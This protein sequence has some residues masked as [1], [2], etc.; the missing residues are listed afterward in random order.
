MNFLLVEKKQ[1]WVSILIILLM[2]LQYVP[3]AKA[4]AL[5]T[6]WSPNPIATPVDLYGVSYGGGQW[7][8]VGEGTTIAQSTDGVNWTKKALAGTVPYAANAFYDALYTGSKW[9]IVGAFGSLIPGKGNM[10]QIYTSP[11]G[12]SWTSKDSKVFGVGSNLMSIA[13]NGNTLVAVGNVNYVTP[14]VTTS[15]DGGETW[16]NY[17]SQ[18]GS[19]RYPLNKV[20]YG[21][22]M[23]VAVGDNGNLFT[24]RNG[25]D[26]TPQPSNTIGHLFG[27]VYTN[28][29]FYVVGNGVL[30]TSTDGVTWTNNWM[31]IEYP[32]IASSG[33]ESVIVDIMGKVLSSIDG[34]TW[35]DNNSGTTT[36]LWN[37]N[38]GNGKFVTV[39]AAGITATRT[40]IPGYVPSSNADLS[41]LSLS[42]GTLTP[43][44][45]AA[46]MNYT[47]AVSNQNSIDVT[48]LT[49]DA[50]AKVT[51][52]GMAPVSGNK[53]T[54]PLIA[55]ANT[56]AIKVTAEDN[57]TTRTY[58]VTIT[59]VVGSPLDPF[60]NA[61]TVDEMRTAMEGA[62]PL[63]IFQSQAG[64]D[65]FFSNV[66]NDKDY[67]YQ[68][69]LDNRGGGFVNQKNL[70]DVIGD[71]IE[72]R[73]PY[74][75]LHET[76]D[77]ASMLYFAYL[78]GPDFDFGIDLSG[79]MSFIIDENML[80][81]DKIGAKLSARI[82]VDGFV[83]P[84]DLQ[85]ALD[86]SIQEYVSE[87]LV[88]DKAN[89]LIGYAAGDSE[90]HV[91][92]NL[93]LPVTGNSGLT[94]RII[95]TSNYSFINANGN[96]T[97]PTSSQGN[98]TVT[99]TATM[100]KSGAVAVK[101]FTVL[102]K[103]L[104]ITGAEAV[105]Q[106]KSLLDI[107]YNGTDSASSVTQNVSLKTSGQNGTTITWSSNAPQFI[108][109][110]GTV[111][112]PSFIQ[113]DQTVI[114]TATITKNGATATKLFTLTL[115][116]M[117][118]S[119][120]EA[121][122]NDKASLD[123]GYN[124]TDSASSV[125][126]NVMLKTAGQFGSTISWS[127]NSPAFIAADGTVTRPTYLQ[128]DQTVTLTATIMKNGVVDTKQFML[129]IVK[130]PMSD[131]EAVE[132][133]KAG[134]NV[135]YNGS[136][137]N[138]SVTQNVILK[139]AGEN[140]TTLTW[141]SNSPAFIAADG[142]VT[143]PTYLQGDQTVILTATITKNGA[144]DTKPFTLT[145]P[146]MP[147]SDSEAVG[148]DKAGLE[149]GYNGTDSAASVMQ[150]VILKTAG[151]AGTTISWSTDSPAFITADGKV[152]RP[153]Y[154][155]GDQT[156][157]LTATIMKNGAVDTKQF[158][159]TVV[160]LPMSDS[161]AVMLDKAGLNVGYNGSD[162]ATSVTQKVTLKTVGGNGTTITWSSNSPAF[163][164]ADG[165]VTRP[166]YLQGD[167]TV[168]LTATIT[169]NGATD[170]KPF[171]LTLP[172]MP[173]SDSEA[174]GIDK[175]GLE[176]G[177]NG[178]DSAS[179]VAQNVILKTAGPAGTTISWSTDSPAFIAADGKVTR[180]TYLQGD[181]TV[182]LT[183]TI[184]KNG[185]VDTKQFTV[186]VVKLPMS[187]WE[188]V[189]IEKAGL[190][191]GYNGADSATSVTQN[192][193][194]KTA[195]ENGTTISW[196]SNTPA[197][198]AAD[199]K[200]TR[201]T[202]LQGDQT[203]TLT[204]T[205]MKNGAVDTKQFTLT[206][207]KLPMNDSE[208]VELDKAGLNV[209]Y[210]VLDSATSVIQNVT[211][212][213]V[214]EN[215]TTITWSSNSAAFVAA[216]GTVTRPS[217]TEGDQ[218]VTLTATITKNGATDIKTFTL[219]L[220]KLPMTDA[221]AVTLD[222]T[223]LEIGYNGADNANSV[224]DNVVLE[225]AGQYGTTITWSSSNPSF[226]AVDGTVTRPTFTQGDQIVTLTT[227]IT[228][229]GATDIKTFTITLP[230]LPMT[231]AE[232]VTLFKTSL[233]IG[234]NGADNA[235]SVTDNIVLETAGQFGT[236]ITWSSSNPSFIAADGTVTRPTFT[237]G[238]QVVTLTATITKNG[239][240]DIKTFTLTLPKLPMTDAEAVMLDKTSLE[241]GYNG[242]DNANSVTDNIVLETAGQFGTTITWS[243]SNPSV[244]AADGTVTRPT[245]TQGDQI[246]T[247]TATIT[248][249][250]ATDIKTFTL[251]LTKLPI[252]DSEAVGIEKDSLGIGY[253]GADTANSV[254]NHLILKTAGQ[255]GTTVTWSS[256]APEFVAA[257]G[258]VNRP[259]YTQ[260]DQQVNLTAA[261]HRGSVTEVK[262]FTL[263]LPHLPMTDAEAV[264]IEKGLLEI[265]YN[266]NNNA[267]SVTTNVMLKT[268]GTNGTTIAW[269]SN[270]PVHVTTDGKVTRPEYSNGHLKVTVTAT[271]TK[272]SSSTTKTFV[273]TL[274]KLPKPPVNEPVS[275]TI[276]VDVVSGDGPN[277]FLVQTEIKRTTDANGVIKDHVTFTK[278][279]AL[280][281]IERM[282][283]L[284]SKTARI[285][286][287]DS[288][289]KV[290]EVTVTVPKE[291]V[292]AL[293]DAGI[294]L[295]V[296]TE[297]GSIFISK[298]SYANVNEDLYFRI[299]PVKDDKE[300]D[301]I[302]N[303]AKQDQMVREIGK[304]NTDSITILGRS[305]EIETNMQNHRVTLTFPVGS[306]LPTD[307]TARKE[308]LDNLV[309]FIE[310]SDGTKEVLQ[311]KV[312][313][314][315]EGN[316]G[317]EFD[318][319]K[320]STFTML[321]VKGAKDY[322]SKEEIT[323]KP[324]IKGYA[325]GNFN[326]N[327]PI[328]RA[329]MAA[330]LARNLGVAYSGNEVPSFVD[331]PK[332]HWAFIEIE[333]VNQT[334]IMTGSVNGTFQPQ[335]TITRAQM[336]TIAYRWVQKECQADAS[337]YPFC[338]KV[339]TKESVSFKDISDKHWANEAIAVMAA[340]GMME[341]YENNTFRPN[342]KLTRAQAVKVLNRLFKREPLNGATTQTFKDVL[343]THWAY[344]EIEEAA[345]EHIH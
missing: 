87:S 196:S 110:D 213:T 198:I 59:N 148:I 131:V 333:L 116:K 70:Q 48:A 195:G 335:A 217:Y 142:T 224:T 292:K 219:T 322:F 231:D 143:R 113:G 11:D 73:S 34:V 158:T 26:W 124:G 282:K 21:G 119:D 69:M 345:T 130:L 240:T 67:V 14:V 324:Y 93:T 243:S 132:L 13:Q 260:G 304:N 166:T 302:K 274:L 259:S 225:T 56:V 147:M 94:T 86:E 334:G 235:N 222:K 168:I 175:A 17:S 27:A 254:T 38:Y 49:A 111:M 54:V 279:K 180:P 321:Y 117:P 280:A 139:T 101:T 229:N 271:I 61:A 307:P 133:D 264:E 41:N 285:M 344:K 197:F 85:A 319:N 297:N 160:K 107:G 184:M 257:D 309:I 327:A 286:L 95:W 201:P 109:A 248:K 298:E 7:I 191:I 50:K 77:A 58:T 112:R 65:S 167:Q 96:V 28:G 320:F 207:V 230:K 329:Q 209:G 317:I 331:T 25:A 220:P 3:T 72:K 338:E 155:Q 23:F 24:S 90:N 301:A 284:A 144:R 37:V 253:N 296:F 22:G 163:I 340:T 336:A 32:T 134:L 236:T 246:V 250:G 137:S 75:N 263:F 118:M 218:V 10:A 303:R 128:G 153:T 200:V 43:S 20:I 103:A 330:M 100:V 241:I 313:D 202:Y 174:V 135:G 64:Y 177:Y 194:L 89:L 337:A 170:R 272:G 150:N 62:A 310:H 152:T 265:G 71:G 172:K 173:M 46:T 270:Q 53:V 108:A 311:G 57:V 171:T 78:L 40:A 276:V 140:G 39:G 114:L 35:T 293:L 277:R 45:T 66:K 68:Y 126:Q 326:P 215:G 63:F 164:A 44:F 275:E 42:A 308:I 316:L 121:V 234:Y 12:S 15:T 36:D 9:V 278:E 305:M 273:L 255:Y 190:D 323:H 141:S 8:A 247:L 269:S 98:T 154:L 242:A 228:K 60:N 206:I 29:K 47:A 99:L 51:V 312:V 16:T 102:V 249:N 74:M 216:D 256:T 91:T 161:E 106:D 295:E 19:G 146:K 136:D 244:I 328:T 2:L 123:I 314:Y 239:A 185:A 55:G 149:I 232:A 318:V 179:S 192:V 300:S 189:G 287:P 315:K 97:R 227:T 339:L 169:K 262:L 80:E 81:A 125:T 92:Q 251:N 105:I 203:V 182:T 199:G 176:I 4:E 79:Y 223:S 151:P 52:N 288:L 30:L 162:S 157:T 31:P 268:T 252:N 341:G 104:E 289:D 210:K 291:A 18:I 145:L 127:T 233:E 343:V 6:N 83:G 214:G 294:D 159:V 178:T 283:D 332:S 33:G 129:T 115:P 165:T 156:V 208:A 211:L 261:I 193:I 5:S 205:I 204:A 258:T 237:Q 212:K 281:M 88:S 138:S 342:E 221:E 122:G 266:D 188:S 186:T 120:S 226:I 84:A 238:D 76:K 267:D 325:D 181:Q 290:S 187:D 299:V 82:P 183:A 245:F 306:S 1:R